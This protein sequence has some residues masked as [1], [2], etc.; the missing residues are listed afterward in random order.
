[1]LNKLLFGNKYHA[2]TTNKVREID[3]KYP[4]GDLLSQE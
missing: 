3:E 4:L 2:A 1:M